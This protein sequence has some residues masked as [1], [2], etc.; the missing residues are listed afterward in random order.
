MIR[1][2]YFRIKWTYNMYKKLGIIE[3][4]SLLFAFLLKH[5]VRVNVPGILHPIKIRAGTSDISV[6]GQI[7]VDEEYSFPT[8]IRPELI[9]DGGANVGYASIFFA[10]KYKN[11]HIIAVEP[12]K[13]NIELLK[14]NT[15]YYPNIEIIESAIWNENTYL[16]VKDIGLGNW[17][18]IVE[19]TKLSDIG[20][21][22]AITIQ[23]LLEE[24]GY[25]KIDILKLDIEGSEK[26]IFTNNYEDW[27]DKVSI[28]IIEL[29]DQMKS[30][31]SNAFYS[32]IKNYSFKKTQRGENVVLEFNFDNLC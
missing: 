13:S 10:N 12:E 22:K 23:T 30:G 31:C 24:S 1:R 14:E 21:F 26:E 32:A 4:T 9:I 27:L 7:F 19:K 18:F 8:D 25:E 20:A 5:P 29:H 15:S 2:M 6:F 3:G 17:G 16:K 28:L 11:A